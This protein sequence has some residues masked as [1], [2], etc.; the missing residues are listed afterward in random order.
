[1]FSSSGFSKSAFSPAAWLFDDE[2][3][4]G[5]TPEPGAQGPIGVRRKVRRLWPQPQPAETEDDELAL[6]QLL[7]VLRG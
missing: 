3:Q 4:P 6:L 1:V 5:V 2:P 7:G